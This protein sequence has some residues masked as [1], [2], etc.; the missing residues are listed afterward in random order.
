MAQPTIS[1]DPEKRGDIY[2]RYKMPPVVTKIEGSG[3]GIKTVFPNILDVCEAINRPSEVLMKFFQFECG[4]Q[5]TVSR[6]QKCW[7]MGQF[8]QDRIQKVLDDFVVKFVLCDS[9]RSPETN[10]VVEGKR[11]LS[12]HCAACGR[13][14]TMK[15]IHRV[16]TFMI[17]YYMANKAELEK[18]TTK[19]PVTAEQESAAAAAA[20]PTTTMPS[21]AEKKADAAATATTPTEG[22]K[23]TVED[24][25]ES[26]IE[27]TFRI[28]KNLLASDPDRIDHHCEAISTHIRQFLQRYCHEDYFGVLILFYVF[29]LAFPDRLCE[30]IQKYHALI[31]VFTSASE[32]T[33]QSAYGDEPKMLEIRKAE[34]KQ[35]VKVLKEAA[36]FFQGASR[37]YYTIDRLIHCIFVMYIEGIVDAGNIE[38]WLEKP[39]ITKG[40]PQELTDELYNKIRPLTEWLG[41]SINP[42]TKKD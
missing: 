40:S 42:K 26:P 28:F 24:D 23:N 10:F 27:T 7:L 20:P 15:D 35:R 34:A 9:C 16:D 11:T 30:M 14:R 21:A 18:R 12:S 38:K 19:V 3:N 17:N 33:L 5:R 25:V 22:E 1:V 6:D 36:K 8:T 31:Q 13:A 41:I 32:I 29:D 2:Y 4:A 37:P 39:F